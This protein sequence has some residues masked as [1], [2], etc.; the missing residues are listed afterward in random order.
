MK[1]HLIIIIPALAI[2]DLLTSPIHTGAQ[3]AIAPAVIAAIISAVG[4]MAAASKGQQSA[5]DQANA[6]AATDGG[7][8]QM[9]SAMSKG[10]EG[11]ARDAVG[12]RDIAFA[13][14]GKQQPA[15]EQL[16]ATLSSVGGGGDA[17]ASKIS[18]AQQ[19][20][21][22]D[23][24]ASD[25]PINLQGVSDAVQPTDAPIS[26][27]MPIEKIDTP[28][29][30]GPGT[31]IPTIEEGTGGG[32]FEGMSTMDKMAMAASLASLLRGPGPPPPPSAGGGP[33]INM[34]PMSLRSMYGRR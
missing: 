22:K 25:A 14:G 2:I 8:I 23:G 34:Q 30:T 16:L 7:G 4:G 10:T 33:G 24:V 5:L 27:N 28:S 12:G 13:T 1:R 20:A 21:D 29:I 9:Q 11:A 17:S 32:M 18:E 3:V 19:L 31:K 6:A 26:A 15:I